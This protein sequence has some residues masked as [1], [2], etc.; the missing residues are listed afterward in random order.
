MVNWRAVMRQ[1]SVPLEFLLQVEDFS[2]L[3][4][5]EKLEKEAVLARRTVIHGACLAAKTVLQEL[6]ARQAAGEDAPSLVHVP[7]QVARE[8]FD[9]ASRT[10]VELEALQEVFRPVAVLHDEALRGSR[11][12]YLFLDDAAA[13]SGTVKALTAVAAVHSSHV[14]VLGEVHLL[15]PAHP[16]EGR[17]R[18]RWIQGRRIQPASRSER[19]GP[20][21][22]LGKHNLWRLNVLSWNERLA[23]AAL[24]GTSLR[25]AILL[26]P[27]RLVPKVGS[28]AETARET[29]RTLIEVPLEACPPHLRGPLRTMPAAGARERPSMFDVAGDL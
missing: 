20:Y 6:R 11:C 13:P 28:V 21:W 2:F 18:R 22:R 1:M 14:R 27:S 15:P 16:W 19:G 12:G 9:M 7:E 24:V 29:G 17:T 5:T 26:A 3:W 10:E 23:L 4:A 25:E 8:A